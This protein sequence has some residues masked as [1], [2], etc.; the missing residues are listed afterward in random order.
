MKKIFALSLL[1]SFGLTSCGY[2]T[3]PTYADTNAPVEKVQ[4]IKIEKKT[5]GKEVI[6]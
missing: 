2:Y 1:I 4:D 6:G 3:C 5:E